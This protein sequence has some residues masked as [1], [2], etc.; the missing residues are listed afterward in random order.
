MISVIMLTFN[1]ENLVTRAIESILTQTYRDFE[2]I[3]V[4]NGS[5]DA[6]G[7]IAD[8]YAAKDDRICVIHRERGNIGAGR[9]TGLDAARGEYIAF[10]DDDDWAEPDFLEFLLKL[11]EENQAD[12]SICGAADKVFDEK[13]IMTAEE[14]LIALMWRKKYNMAFPTKLF[15][16]ELVE[17]LRFPEDGSYDD[18]ALMY[19]LLAEAKTVAYHGLPKYTFYRH[20]GNNSAWTTNHD[21]LTP[22]TLDEYLAAYRVR[23]EWLSERFPDSAAAFRYFEWSFMISMVEKIKRLKIQNC[24]TQLAAMERE[25]RAH[26]QEFLSTPEILRFEQEWME[27]Y[28]PEC[29]PSARHL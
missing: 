2:F 10:I 13:K 4:D 1:R 12:I 18:I 21:L 20:E 25:L 14:A 5:T 15:R 28:V 6:S 19:R 8:E 26:R 7:R 11:L 27:R 22:E 24:D 3:I 29:T 16:R 17:T 9:N 23:T